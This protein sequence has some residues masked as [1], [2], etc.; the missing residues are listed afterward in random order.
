[1]VSPIFYMEN[2]GLLN[3]DPTE[4]VDITDHIETKLKMLSMH[5][6]QIT[7]LGDHDG[8]D[9]I[10]NTRMFARVR[11]IQCGVKYAEGFRQC[12]VDHRNT[13]KRLL[14]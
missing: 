11:G 9:V 5:E 6:S 8:N 12:N 2:S 7:W 4:Y 13:T 14:P 1:M 10:E 3:C